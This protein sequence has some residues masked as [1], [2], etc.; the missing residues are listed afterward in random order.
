[1][2]TDLGLHDRLDVGVVDAADAKG[3]ADES[4]AFF[5]R[6]DEQLCGPDEPML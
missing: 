3:T 2:K 4:V 1:M 6:V 5:W